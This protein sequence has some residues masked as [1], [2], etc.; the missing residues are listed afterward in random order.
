LLVQGGSQVS[1]Q[2]E[3]VDGQIVFPFR[4]PVGFLLLRSGFFSGFFHDR[5]LP[6]TDGQTTGLLVPLLMVGKDQAGLEET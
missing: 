5:G 6:E 3:G 1:N 2:L 4:F